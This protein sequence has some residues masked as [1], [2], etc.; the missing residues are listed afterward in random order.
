MKRPHHFWTTRE[1][2]RLRVE[3]PVSTHQ[4]LAASFAPHTPTSIAS[5]AQ[6]LGLRK[7]G[8]VAKN[9]PQFGHDRWKT[10][11]NAHVPTFNFK[12]GGA[13]EETV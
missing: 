7:A 12:A 3:Y 6:A 9:G 8:T 10:I 4:Q 11:A 13:A 5:T 2:A 1:L